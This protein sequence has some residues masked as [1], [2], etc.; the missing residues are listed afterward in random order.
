MESGLVV[1]VE[2]AEARVSPLRRAFDPY[3]NI[4]VPAHITVLYPFLTPSE[5]TSKTL[6]DVAEAVRDMQPFS[7]ELIS[8]E[9]FDDSIIYL[10]PSPA[11][12]FVELTNKLWSAFPEFP[13]FGGRFDSVIPHIASA[14]LTSER[15]RR[16]SLSNLRERSR[17]V[18]PHGMLRCSS[19]IETV[20]RWAGK[21]PLEDERAG[22]TD[23]REVHET[24]TPEGAPH[25]ASRL[26]TQPPVG[27]S[28]RTKINAS[29]IA[30]RSRSSARLVG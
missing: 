11:E 24:P 30:Q 16:R 25:P 2:E 15:P 4:G 22:S 26:D 29:T 21:C 8:V 3:A 5:I 23:R 18:L 14:D 6:R 27:G 1:V 17:S 12:P 10:A 19:R 7:F 9:S 28:S 20:G 13:P